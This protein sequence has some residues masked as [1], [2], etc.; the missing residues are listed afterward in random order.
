MGNYWAGFAD[1][2]IDLAYIPARIEDAKNEHALS[3]RFDQIVNSMPSNDIVPGGTHLGGWA[4]NFWKQR[5]RVEGSKK[6]GDQFAGCLGV[7]TL[8]ELFD[9][10]QIVQRFGF[11]L[12]G[13]SLQA[14]NFFLLARDFLAD[15]NTA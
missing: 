14:R 1:A 11:D 4:S 12:D 10:H 7:S 9:F 5:N 3:S 15:F 6:H 8:N 13:K 2:L